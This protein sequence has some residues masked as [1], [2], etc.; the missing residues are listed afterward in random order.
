MSIITE[1]FSVFAI[2]KDK[3]A[4]VLYRYLYYTRDPR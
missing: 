1:G 2:R 4:R 3:K